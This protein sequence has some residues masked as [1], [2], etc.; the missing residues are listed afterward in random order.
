MPP[1][2]GPGHSIFSP[3][4]LPAPAAV[5]ATPRGPCPRKASHSPQPSVKYRSAGVCVRVSAK[6]P[7]AGGLGASTHW[8]FSILLLAASVGAVCRAEAKKRPVTWPTLLR[9][10]P[11]LQQQHLLQPHSHLYFHFS[12]PARQGREGSQQAGRDGDVNCM[13]RG[14]NLAAPGQT[15]HFAHLCGFQPLHQSL[16]PPVPGYHSRT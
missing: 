15:Q 5:S 2:K 13:G 7:P 9:Q 3:C 14:R 6:L 10:E 16:T 12:L 4:L 11:P 1:L 8:Y